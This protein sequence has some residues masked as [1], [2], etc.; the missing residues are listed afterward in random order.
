MGINGLGP[1]IGMRPEEFREYAPKVRYSYTEAEK[2]KQR[3]DRE[4]AAR[5]DFL[6]RQTKLHQQ[7]SQRLM[8]LPVY[9]ETKNP[10]FNDAIPEIRSITSLAP[11]EQINRIRAITETIDALI[12][13]DRRQEKKLCHKLSILLGPAIY[14]IPI[15][16]RQIFYNPENLLYQQCYWLLLSVAQTY[17]VPLTYVM[18]R[19]ISY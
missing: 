2:R 13:S 6:K 15:K 18:K 1:G 8:A 10:S 16:T 17:F 5:Q 14:S 7:Y 19:P 9:L 3:A 12:K 4:E 11:I